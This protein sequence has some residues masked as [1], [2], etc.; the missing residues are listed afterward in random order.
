MIYVKRMGVE[1]CDLNPCSEGDKLMCGVV[2]FTISL[3][4]ILEGLQRRNIGLDMEFL[5]MN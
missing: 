3:S 4:S 5:F 2:L 1:C